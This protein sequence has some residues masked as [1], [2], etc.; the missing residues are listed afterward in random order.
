MQFDINLNK[1]FLFIYFFFIIFLIKTLKYTI[2]VY[3]FN[4]FIGLLT[5]NASFTYCVL[6]YACV[7][8]HLCK[9]TDHRII[10][11]CKHCTLSFFCSQLLFIFVIF[12][13]VC[14][15]FLIQLEMCTV[16]VCLLFF[17]YFVFVAC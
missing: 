14:I 5:C 4:G 7:Y 2:D 10:N 15:F 9:V 12:L 6:V 3:D 8:T 17:L 16:V 11:R 13:R 1:Q